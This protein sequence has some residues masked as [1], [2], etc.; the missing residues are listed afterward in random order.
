MHRFPTIH[1]P[2]QRFAGRK[3][4]IEIGWEYSQFTVGPD[5]RTN[6]GDSV[7][8][9]EVFCSKTNMEIIIEKLWVSDECRNV[10]DSVSLLEALDPPINAPKIVPSKLNFWSF[11]SP[12]SWAE[13][14][15]HRFTIEYYPKESLREPSRR[16]S[17]K[18]GEHGSRDALFGSVRNHLERICQRI[19]CWSLAST[20][21]NIEG[22]YSLLTWFH[23]V[24][25][26]DHDLHEAK[27]AEK[28]HMHPTSSWG[29]RRSRVLPKQW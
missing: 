3:K 11:Y 6:S 5:Y 19:S 20:L 15:S 26:V 21:G 23:S 14:V 24:D 28:H 22:S 9:H 10:S 13:H 2:L 1:D 4:W 7:R 16:D 18:F 25:K 29:R 17:I 8:S 12:M 27:H